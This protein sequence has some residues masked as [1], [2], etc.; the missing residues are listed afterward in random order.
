[1]AKEP[2]PSSW[3]VLV[4]QAGSGGGRKVGGYPAMGRVETRKDPAILLPRGGRWQ[5]I[6][7]LFVFLHIAYRREFTMGGLGMGESP[8]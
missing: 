8:G 6:Y 2:N 5:G 4:L 1:M 3:I 7:V